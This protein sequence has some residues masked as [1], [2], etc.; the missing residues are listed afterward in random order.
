MTRYEQK[1]YGDVGRLAKAGE[2]IADALE[3]GAKSPHPLA[4]RTAT[5]SEVNLPEGAHGA[6]VA[7]EFPPEVTRDGDNAVAVELTNLM[8]VCEGYA[9]V[10]NLELLDLSL[11]ATC[12]DKEAAHV[13][14]ERDS[15]ADPD[16]RDGLEQRLEMLRR[17][18]A[19]LTTA[20]AR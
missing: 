3:G 4:I 14:E 18:R 17:L 19:M 16:E 1:F 2:R 7:L 9:T 13:E 5:E 6:I 12:V 11:L 15:R 20:G 8:Y 10:E